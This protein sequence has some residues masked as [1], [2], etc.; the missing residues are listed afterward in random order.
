MEPHMSET[1]DLTARALLVARNLLSFA[2]YAAERFA[3]RQ[4]LRVAA[5]LRA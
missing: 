5:S 4:T 3:T 1:N 2:R